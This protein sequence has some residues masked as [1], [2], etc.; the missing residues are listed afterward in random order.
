MVYED[1][2][3]FRLDDG[4]VDFDKCNCLAWF[5]CTALDAADRVFA[6][7]AVVTER[8]HQKLQRPSFDRW[9]RHL[10]DNGVENRC[11]IGWTAWTLRQFL[12]GFTV[13]TN[14]VVDRVVQL[15]IADSQLQE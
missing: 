1:F 5:G 12:P 7:I 11:Q 8:G 2:V 14:G 6:E 15:V 3:D 9:C 13:A 10:M 4:A